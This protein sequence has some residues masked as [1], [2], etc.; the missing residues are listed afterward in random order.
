MNDVAELAQVGLKTVSRV[1]NN[2]GYVSAETAER[3]ERAIAQIGYR[4]NEIRRRMRP[5]QGSSDI[6]LLVGDL[7]NPFFAA[8]AATVISEARGR[9]FGVMIATADESP[10]AEGAAIGGGVGRRAGGVV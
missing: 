9:G 1:V 10:D 2:E 3:V 6:G 5:G 8:I 7:R 4:R